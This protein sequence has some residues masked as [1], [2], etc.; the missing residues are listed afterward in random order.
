MG[1]GLSELQKTMLELAKESLTQNWDGYVYF[2]NVFIKVYGW[3]AP[4]R[5]GIGIFEGYGRFSK[6]EIGVK[7]YMA[8]KIAVRK[9]AQRL[10]KRGLIYIPGYSGAGYSLTMKGK[11]FLMAKPVRTI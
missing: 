11:E 7:R 5:R 6:K 1:R 8:A 2:A 4:G 9:S 3:P 10:V